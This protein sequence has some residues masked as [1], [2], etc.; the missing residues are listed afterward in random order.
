[1]QVSK[2]VRDGRAMRWPVRLALSVVIA[3]G[4]YD[5][6]VGLY[7]LFASEPWRAHG[8]ATLWRSL[9]VDYASL[10][11][12]ARVLV[13]SLFRRLGAFS[14]FAG[15][16]SL[17]VALTER[18]E[19]MKLARFMALF[20]VA[21]LAFGVTD[22]TYFAGTRYHLIKQVIGG[23]WVVSLGVLFWHLRRVRADE[24]ESQTTS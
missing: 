4:V 24:R 22:G 2:T 23:V 17:F 1:M 12:D 6:S 11:P 15:C 13:M 14:L 9:D 5:A 21:G 18:R 16:V 19:P 10:A 20:V 7:M 8:P 3:V